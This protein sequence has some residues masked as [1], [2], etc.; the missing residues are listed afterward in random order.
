MGLIDRLPRVP[1]RRQLSV[2]IALGA[3]LA[4][5]APVS[6]VP[7]TGP[8]GNFKHIVVIY[9][10]N[11]SFDNLY[12]LWGDVN[13]QHVVGLADRDAAHTLQKA[14][15]GSIYACLDQLDFN[16]RTVNQAGQAPQTGGPLSA[17]CPDSSGGTESHTRADGVTVT[18][19]SHFVNGPYKIDDFIGPTDVTCPP[20]T[21]LFGFSNGI[22]KRNT[23]AGATAGGCTRDLVHRFYQ[24]Q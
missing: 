6:A 4:L 16:L 1:L 20:L 21:N 14:Q 11:H 15:D 18:Y 10:E 5:A 12:G 3:L 9:E 19:D 22:D 17:T 23:V 2:A 8:L 24:E 7:K 13:G